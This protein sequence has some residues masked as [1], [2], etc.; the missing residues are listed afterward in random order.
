[1]P[2]GAGLSG[3]LDNDA[4]WKEWRMTDTGGIVVDYDLMVPA[5][6]GVGL[7]TDVYRPAGPGRFPLG[8]HALG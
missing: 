1:M 2:V 3:E 7:A 4:R 8:T 6:D 5:R